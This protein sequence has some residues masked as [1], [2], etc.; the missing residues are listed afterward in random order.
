MPGGIFRRTSPAS[1]GTST[2]APKAAAS[3]RQVAAQ[4]KAKPGSTV[5][6]TGHTDTV[7]APDYNMALA[8]RR[9]DAV[10]GVGEDG[11]Q[12]LPLV[13]EREA[14]RQ[15]AKQGSAQGRLQ[16][17]DVVDRFPTGAQIRESKEILHRQRPNRFLQGL[18][19]G[20]VQPGIGNGYILRQ[21]RADEA[22]HGQHLCDVTEIFHIEYTS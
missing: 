7:G 8:Q 3:I 17:F 12:H 15:A 20:D 9:S 6:L 22:G 11:R 14:A 2:L 19:N 1:V 13:G 21:A 18:P 4:D 16:P 5:I 10:E